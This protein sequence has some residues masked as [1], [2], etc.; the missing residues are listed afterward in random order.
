MMVKK[1]SGLTFKLK[2]LKVEKVSNISQKK[3]NHEQYYLSQDESLEQP[4]H[5]DRTNNYDPHFT[6]Y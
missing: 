4:C 5:I 1:E 2:S 3:K 6:D